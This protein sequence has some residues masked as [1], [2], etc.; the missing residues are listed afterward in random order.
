VIV[1]IPCPK[2]CEHGTPE[3]WGALVLAATELAGG[4]EISYVGTY[5]PD[6]GDD[7]HP[8]H[9]WL[10]AP[11]WREASVPALPEPERAVVVL[12]HKPGEYRPDVWTGDGRGAWDPA[13]MQRKVI[14]VEPEQYPEPVVSSRDGMV[15]DTRPQA[16]RRLITLLESAGW[17]VAL[18]QYAEGFVQHRSHGTP[19]PSPRASWGIRAERGGAAAIAVYMGQSKGFKWETLYVIAGRFVRYENVGDF[20]RAV[21]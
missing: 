17:T 7:V 1:Q 12:P 14:E 20:E 8:V 4:R 21:Q 3:G 11:D 18:L 6:K 13:V 10:V 19:S 2:D 9:S 16:V 5:G 15:P